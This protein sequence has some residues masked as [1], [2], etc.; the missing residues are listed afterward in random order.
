MPLN[1]N[2]SMPKQEPDQVPPVQ[3][4]AVQQPQMV[5]AGMTSYASPF[6]NPYAILAG[7]RESVLSEQPVQAKLGQAF[8]GL[9][10]SAVIGADR[11]SQSQMAGTQIFGGAAA[12]LGGLLGGGYAQGGVQLLQ[13][14]NQRVREARVERHQ[15][16]QEA[17]TGLKTLSDIVNTTSPYSQKNLALQLKGAQSQQKLG[18]DQ[19][20][21][22]TRRIRAFNADAAKQTQLAEVE[23]HNKAAEE[24]KKAGLT[25]AASKRELM[26]DVANQKAKLAVQ[27]QEM[28]DKVTRE[29]YNVDI[30]KNMA[31]LR[32]KY[33][34]FNAVQARLATEFQ[35]KTKMLSQKRDKDGNLVY[36]SADGKPVDIANLFDLGVVGTD[37]NMDNALI[38]PDEEEE[39]RISSY[40]QSVQIPAQQTP[41]TPQQPQAP[42]PASILAPGMNRFKA[43]AAGG[44]SPQQ[45]EMAK[46]QWARAIEQTQGIPFQQAMQLINQGM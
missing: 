10:D 16:Q 18:I 42:N 12:A 29:G 30:Q 17:L 24:L 19:D 41:A 38:D 9:I 25:E 22:V 43:L 2:F 15:R 5:A 31:N 33:Q 45:L 27:L 23:R 13:D 8:E 14:V 32:Q 6:A 35:E 1:F 39:A 40:M 36:Q 44:A 28:R 26:R 3:M 21:A 46:T 37:A 11:H 4:T 34:M 7:G 20:N